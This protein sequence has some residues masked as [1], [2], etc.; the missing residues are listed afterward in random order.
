MIFYFIIPSPLSAF[1]CVSFKFSELLYY[2]HLLQLISKFFIV[3]SYDSHHTG[4]FFMSF[5]P[6][7]MPSLPL[8]LSL[9]PLSVQILSILL[10]LNVFFSLKF[11]FPKLKVVSVPS[12]EHLQHFSSS[13]QGIYLYIMLDIQGNDISFL[14]TEALSHQFYNYPSISYHSTSLPAQYM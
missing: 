14:R 2:S 11:L 5:Y 10:S 13:S 8:P 12:F 3:V 1:S 7:E 6:P 4:S 9:F